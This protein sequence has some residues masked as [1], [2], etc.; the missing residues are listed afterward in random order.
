MNS[1]VSQIPEEPS[2]IRLA[3]RNKNNKNFLLGN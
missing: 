1:T 3:Q 2:F